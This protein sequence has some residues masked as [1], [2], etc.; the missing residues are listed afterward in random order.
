MGLFHMFFKVFLG[1]DA[2]FVAMRIICRVRLI[3]EVTSFYCNT[4]LVIA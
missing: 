3:L 4:F 1:L 2:S